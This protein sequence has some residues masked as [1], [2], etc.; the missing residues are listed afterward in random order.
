LLRLDALTPEALALAP[1]ICAALE[2]TP[3][4]LARGTGL[5]LQLGHRVSADFDWF[6]RPEGFP[7]SLR[8]RLIALGRPLVP[9]QESR[10]SFECLLAGVNCS[11]FRYPATFGAAPD[12]LYRRPL[13]PV[14]DIGVMKLIAVSQ[15]GA[16]KDFF[17]LYEILKTR[18]FPTII[19]RARTMLS[20]M[21]VNPVHL[22]KSLVYFEDADGDPDPVVLSGADWQVVKRFF[23]DR[24]REH[25]DILSNELAPP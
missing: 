21:P 25:T 20:E 10:R 8:S 14:E 6:C 15:R 13:A 22:A 4:V 3:F 16:K 1:S 2:G 18:D 7:E 19:R 24:L 17:D 11:F 5:A 9:I 12:F 23:T